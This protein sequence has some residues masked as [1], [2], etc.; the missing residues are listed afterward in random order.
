MTNN[1]NNHF[2]MS[3]SRTD[4]D[5][6]NNL[7]SEL[8]GVGLNI[9]FDKSN[10][11]IGD[12]DWEN[13]IRDG[14]KSSLGII[15]CATPNAR[16]SAYARGELQ[17]AQENKIAIYPVWLDGKKY[18]DCISMGFSYIQ[19][20][21]LREDE[22]GYDLNKLEF[23]NKILNLIVKYVMEELKSQNLVN[24]SSKLTNLLRAIDNISADEEIEY[25]AQVSHPLLI[26][27]ATSDKDET[28]NKLI[29]ILTDWNLVEITPHTRFRDDRNTNEEYSTS[30][31]TI[32][33]NKI[34]DENL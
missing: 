6:V 33:G 20:V 8:E 17:I 13:S 34:A 27:G 1:K 4:T 23:I 15:Y 32:L 7:L 9:W 2:F 12:L 10:L 31:L 14:I 25:L 3:Y 22:K 11:S 26:A 5:I 21:D 19:N 29:D 18:T 28:L 16:I 24:D 30:E